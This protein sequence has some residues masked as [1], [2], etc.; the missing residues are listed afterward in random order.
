[1]W[2]ICK[3]CTCKR[4]EFELYQVIN[5][6]GCFNNLSGTSAFKDIEE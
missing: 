6:P 3:R 1:V 5:D 4:A 2:N